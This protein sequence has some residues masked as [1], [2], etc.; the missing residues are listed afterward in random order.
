[1]IPCAP[2][3]RKYWGH[4]QS[5]Q[6]HASTLRLTDK[7]RQPH[8]L[9]CSKDGQQDDGF[10]TVRFAVTIHP[11]IGRVFQRHPACK[12][13]AICD[14]IFVVAPLQEALALV[15]ELKL[16]LKQDLDLD[17]D[18]PKFSCYV[19]GNHLDDDQ[20][21][22]LFK[23]TLEN[24]QSFLDLAAMDAGVYKGTTCCRCAYRR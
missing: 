6:G 8:H 12:G 19:P 20:A 23:D 22:A 15:A 17:L 1:M 4:F 24:R 21:R 11:S 13:A 7:R 9:M 16:I 10:E 2:S 14:Y 18:V 3:L 5:T